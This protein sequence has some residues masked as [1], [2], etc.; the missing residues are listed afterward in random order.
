MRPLRQP[1]VP[2][3]KLHSEVKLWTRCLV[4]PRPPNDHKTPDSGPC[5]RRLRLRRSSEF[6]AQLGEEVHDF[7]VVL[8][9]GHVGRVLCHILEGGPDL[10]IL[11]RS[12]GRNSQ[13][14]I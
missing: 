2:P 11:Q 7:G 9:L 12:E 14:M 8:V 3:F 6:G 1:V 5:R 10:R 4:R 13:V